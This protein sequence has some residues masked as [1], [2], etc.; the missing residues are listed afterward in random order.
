MSYLRVGNIRVSVV[1]NI[2][3]DDHFWDIW[4]P[5]INK[6]WSCLMLQWPGPG[7]CHG[8]WVVLH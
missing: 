6:I 5:V 1:A 2:S 3:T 4:D 8:D 7:K